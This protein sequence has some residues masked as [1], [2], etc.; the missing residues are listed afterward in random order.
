MIMA[1]LKSNYPAAQ[2]GDLE[3]DFVAETI[4][5]LRQLNDLGR[6]K[7]DKEL[8][9]R[10]DRYFEFCQNTGNRPGI[11]SLCMSLSIT[12]TT[13]FN[14]NNG[15]NCTPERQEIIVKAK[16]FIASFMEQ[17]ILRGKLNPAS[18]IFLMKN[19]LNYKDSYSFE[20]AT[21]TQP[22]NKPRQTAAEIA[23]KHKFALEFPEPEKPIL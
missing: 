19:W 16:A 1:N 12:R 17:A 6:P 13:L 8:T 21:E 23:A 7:T 18:G 22:Q 9:E 14:W 4:E 10:I 2:L 20:E 11:E 5:N 15:I 3:P